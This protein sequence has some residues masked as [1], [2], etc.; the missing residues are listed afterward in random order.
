MMNTD[1]LHFGSSYQDKFDPQAYLSMYFKDLSDPVRVFPL[2]HFHEFYK[3]Y[4]QTKANL[5]ILDYGTGPTI[6][7]VISAVPYAAEIVLSD[8]TESNRRELQQWMVKDAKAHDWSPYFKHIVQNL[9]GKGSPET[10]EREEQLRRVTKAIVHCDIT[11]DPPIE[12]GY[13]GPYDVSC[14]L[15]LHCFCRTN[16][17]YAKAVGR[18]SSLLKPGGKIVLYAAEKSTSVVQGHY[19][20]GRENFFS[21][22]DLTQRFTMHCLEQAGFVDITCEKFSV[23]EKS[24]YKPTSESYLFITAT[25]KE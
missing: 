15:C 9:E 25:R 18:L 1:E 24:F 4:G 21:L 5:K 14:C 19:F 17:E 6:A 20:V 13:E 7:Y 16:E 22:S 23:P 10:M 11:Q 3:T 2:K 8:Y 12:R